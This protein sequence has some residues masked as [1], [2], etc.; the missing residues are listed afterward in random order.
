MAIEA[1]WVRILS[2][3]GL[4]VNYQGQT[5]LT[6]PMI[7]SVV[8]IKKFIERGAI[9]EEIKPDET[10][11]KLDLTNFD[12]D[13]GGVVV[14]ADA[15]YAGDIEEEHMTVRKKI[16]EARLKRIQE[17]IF[18]AT[19]APATPTTLNIVSVDPCANVSAA[20]GS[21]VSSL[22]LPTTVDV[23]LS[24]SSVKSL[25]V[26]WNLSTVSLGAAGSYITKGDL[27]LVPGVTNT[28]SL[29]AKVKVVVS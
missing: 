2:P 27:T 28:S 29:Q 5:G 4:T 24:D 25:A 6:R 17:E 11:V 15:Q 19:S 12:S 21:S 22:A 23:L 13:N 20:I 26:T 9:V 14:P 1:K 7:V 16:Q 18:G 3:G 10:T 8:N